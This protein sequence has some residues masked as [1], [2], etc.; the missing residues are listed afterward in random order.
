MAQAPGQ[1]T[2]GAAEEVGRGIRRLRLGFAPAFPHPALEPLRLL[3]RA[4]APDSTLPKTKQALESELVE[5]ARQ[6]FIST[7][8]DCLAQGADV[9]ATDRFGKTAL[10]RAAFNNHFD[11]V[12]S[13]IE[14]GADVNAKDRD[15][16]TALMYAAS[17]LNSEVMELLLGKGARTKELDRDGNTAADIARRPAIPDKQ[18]RRTRACAVL[19]RYEAMEP[20]RVRLAG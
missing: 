8:R 19:V 12:A 13:L 18:R 6:G 17:A 9:N 1:I 5:S 4:P 20:D 14:S 16:Q 2:Q 10:M 15:G 3:P 11:I 7:V